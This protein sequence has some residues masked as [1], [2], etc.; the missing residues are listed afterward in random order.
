MRVDPDMDQIGCTEVP[1]RT[2]VGIVEP[3]HVHQAVYGAVQ[4]A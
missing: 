2:T 4:E 3:K 1:C